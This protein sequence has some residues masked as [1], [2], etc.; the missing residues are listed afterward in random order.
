MNYLG[1]NEFGLNHKSWHQPINFHDQNQINYWLEQ[2]F[3]FYKLIFKKY[4][5]HKN[6]IFVVYEELANPNYLRG[7][8]NKINLD[9]VKDHNFANIK[10]LNKK[11]ININ[12]SDNMYEK[13]KDLYVTFKDKSLIK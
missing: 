8:L 13:T 9:K 6:T 4:S 10:N 11:E 12:F 7:L 3:L 1:H 2:W 5:S